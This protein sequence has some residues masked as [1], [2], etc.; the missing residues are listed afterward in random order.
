MARPTAQAPERIRTPPLGSCTSSS[1]R[2]TVNAVASRGS[3]GLK[4]RNSRQ[5]FAFQILQ[6]RAAAS[7]DVR[8]LIGKAELV[9]RRRGVSAADDR[10]STGIDDRLPDRFGAGGKG[11]DFENTHRTI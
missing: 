5:L 8:Q 4:C 6:S 11:I 3:L 9:R 7:R 2:R 10:E 1:S